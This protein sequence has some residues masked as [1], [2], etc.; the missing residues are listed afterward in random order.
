METLMNTVRV[1]SDD[2]GMQFGIDKCAITVIKRGKLD[3]RNNDIVLGN[4]EKITSLDENNCYKYLG[5]LEVDNIKQ[6]EMKT[7]IEKEYIRRLRKI[8][9]SKLN[10]GNLVKAI[11]T[12]AVSL[13]RYGGGIID[14]NQKELEDMDRRTRKMMHAY[15]AVH[16]RADV[17]RL[18]VQ[19]EDGGRGLMSILDT[20][21]YEDQSMIEYIRTKDSGVVATVKLYTGKQIE[22]SKQVFKDRQTEEKGRLAN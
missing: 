12:W 16:P 19:R 13:V 5:M 22:D 20:V 6:K 9:K 8:L 21:R 4:Q 7:Q 3:N 18:Y 14:W 15:G 17:D 11:N 10:A 2:I 1:F